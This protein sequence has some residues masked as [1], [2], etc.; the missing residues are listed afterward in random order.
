[1]VVFRYALPS[2]LRILEPYPQW[3]LPSM[4]TVIAEISLGQLVPGINADAMN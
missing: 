2:H 4:E 1:V 3:R